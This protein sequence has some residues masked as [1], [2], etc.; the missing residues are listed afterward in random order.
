MERHY[1]EELHALK[2]DILRMGYLVEEAIA[3]SVNS[4][5]K[6][7]EYLARE[8]IAED[9]LV[10]KQEVA[11]DRRGDQLIALHQP[12]AGDLRLICAILKINTMLER[13]GDHAVNIAERTLRL[14][15]EPLL[16]SEIHWPEMAQATRKMLRDALD[17]LMR[18]DVNLAG[19]VLRSDSVVDAYNDQIVDKLEV[20]MRDNSAL[21]RPGLNLVMVSHNLERIGDLANNITEEVI[22]THRGEDVRHHRIYS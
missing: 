20:L 22:Y 6:R 8:V 18:N 11:I 15:E 9:Q 4:L 2:A 10:D 14:I 21:V 1:H 3:K 16:K 5:L 7:N 13:M 19:E 17:A 12:V